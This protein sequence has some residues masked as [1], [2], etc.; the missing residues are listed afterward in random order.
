MAKFVG[1]PGFFGEK[2]SSFVEA[3]VVFF[4]WP[5]EG[6]VFTHAVISA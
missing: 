2:I 6:N 4:T 5:I 3:P 1:D